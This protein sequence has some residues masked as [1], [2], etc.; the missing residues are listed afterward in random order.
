MA[1]AMG[2]NC[3]LGTDA[4]TPGNHGGYGI[5]GGCFE[6]MQRTMLE[7]FDYYYIDRGYFAVS[8]MGTYRVVKNGFACTQMTNTDRKRL[9][10]TRH[11]GL[12]N[13]RKG[14]NVVIACQ[15]DAWHRIVGGEESAKA[16]SERVRDE[17]RRYTDRPIVIREKGHSGLEKALSDAH[18]LVTFGSAVGVEALT[19]GVPVFCLHDCP[20]LPLAKTD[21][22]EIENPLY[23]DNRMD[24]L[25]NLANHQWTLDEIS[26]G[27]FLCGL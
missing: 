11:R 7:G 17:I 14:R 1:S 20:A 9:S 27:G 8:R 2:W 15:S 3:A 18:C 22:S 10:K 4:W 6:Q 13:W 12:D 5:L 24:L 26:R 23:P 25:A 19:M 16:W 21:L